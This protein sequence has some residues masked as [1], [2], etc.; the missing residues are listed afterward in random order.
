[1][2]GQ[3]ATLVP[4]AARR[5]I[6]ASVRCTPWASTVFGERAP[7]SSNHSTGRMRCASSEPC[8]SAAVSDACVWKIASW[9]SRSSTARSSPVS[10][11]RVDGVRTDDGTPPGARRV[12]SQPPVGVVDERVGPER[13]DAGVVGHHRTA[14]Q[15]QT[16]IGC[17]PQARVGEEVHVQRRGHAAAQRLDR[18]CPGADPD[19]RR[20]EHR[21]LGRHDAAEEGLQVEVVGEP[22]EHG[23]RQV[24][25]RVDQA[26]HQQVPGKVDPLRRGHLRLHRSRRADVGD[27][28][29]AYREGRAVDDRVGS[30]DGQQH[31][32]RH[33][34]VDL[35][36]AGHTGV[37]RAGGRARS[38]SPSGSR[39]RDRRGA[40][41][42]PAEPAGAAW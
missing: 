27:A 19:R 12:R 39:Y 37:R 25:V 29:V 6:S 16:R 32:R 3:W 13:R 1:M 8:T 2:P 41:T 40:S 18:R 11:D 38:G 23:H 7:T 14:Q 28:A 22:A 35:L 20:V 24:G 21:R 34:Q 9:A 31:R 10:A 4:L 30:V 26:R 15:P 42:H 17:R 36:R 33:Q 5:S